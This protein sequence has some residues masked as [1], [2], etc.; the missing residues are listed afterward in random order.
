MKMVITNCLDETPYVI[1]AHITRTSG[2]ASSI[3]LPV[4]NFKSKIIEL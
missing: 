4:I 2:S 3:K 1:Y